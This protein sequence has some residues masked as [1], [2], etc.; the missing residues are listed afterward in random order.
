MA[1]C[2]AALLPEPDGHWLNAPPLGSVRAFFPESDVVCS[3]GVALV[4]NID[5]PMLGPDTGNPAMRLVSKDVRAAAGDWDCPIGEVPSEKADGPPAPGI[6]GETFGV[7]WFDGV[8][9]GVNAGE[10]DGMKAGDAFGI[11]DPIPGED[12]GVKL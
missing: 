6:A 4:E 9:I 11:N 5:R 12:P 8:P 7:E 1:R 10:A 2:G 3:G